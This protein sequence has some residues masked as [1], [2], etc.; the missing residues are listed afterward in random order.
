MVVKVMRPDPPLKRKE[1]G[2][3]WLRGLRRYDPYLVFLREIREFICGCK[4][5]G[6][7]LDFVQK[8][9]GLVETDMGL[10]LVSDA[11]LDAQG[12]LAPTVARLIGEG[13]FTALVEE[14]FEDFVTKLLDCDL[15]LSDLHERNLVL[16]V[17][18]D[19]SESFQLIDGLGSSSFIPFKSW[20]L[21]INR[22]SKKKRIVRLRGRMERRLEAYRAGSPMP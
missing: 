2:D 4:A 3:H 5:N 22:R 19:G 6:A 16:A 9:R 10:G 13:K 20:S 12:Q 14:A 17:A 8:V 11:A 21:G 1:G 18:S 7:P 15:V